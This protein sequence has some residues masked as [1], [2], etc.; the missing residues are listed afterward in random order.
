MIAR[1]QLSFSC[2]FPMGPPGPQ[3][4]RT[5]GR[6]ADGAMGRWV[7]G[8]PLR[9]R[10]SVPKTRSAGF[11]GLKFFCGGFTAFDWNSSRI[12]VDDIRQELN[13]VDSNSADCSIAFC[14]LSV[15]AEPSGVS[16]QHCRT[17]SRIFVDN[18]TTRVVISC[19]KTLPTVLLWLSHCF[20]F[21]QEPSGRPFEPTRGK[22]V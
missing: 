6:W 13:T 1:T 14:E 3:G 4:P 20:F 18:V 15:S 10:A 9:G 12:F 22:S 16:D 21:L 2:S 11:W 8:R 19:T 7:R 17:A 5:M